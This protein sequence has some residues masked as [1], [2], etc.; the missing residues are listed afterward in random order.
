MNDNNNNESSAPEED[1]NHQQYL[2]Y[3]ITKNTLEPILHN[4]ESPKRSRDAQ[5]P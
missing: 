3:L 2:H 5:E 4:T 1:K